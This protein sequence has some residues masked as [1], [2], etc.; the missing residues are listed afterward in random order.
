[1]IM[2][3]TSESKNQPQLHVVFIKVTLVIVSV[4]SSKTLTKTVSLFAVYISSQK[5]STVKLF[6][7]IVNKNV[8]QRSQN[9]DPDINPYAKGQLIFD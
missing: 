1:M 2:G 5:N 6:Q 7:L 9:E 4:Y 3:R 8:D